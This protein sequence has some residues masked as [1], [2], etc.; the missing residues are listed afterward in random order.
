MPLSPLTRSFII[1]VPAVVRSFSFHFCGVGAVTGVGGQW[2]SWGRAKGVLSSFVI[3]I[4][5][6]SGVP[7]FVGSF[8]K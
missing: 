4:D 1:V 7:E 8:M 5:Y 6:L 3:N 2:R